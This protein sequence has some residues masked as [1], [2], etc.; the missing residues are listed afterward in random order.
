V[1]TF[2]KHKDTKTPRKG[3]LHFK[4]VFTFP[5]AFVDAVLVSDTMQ[6]RFLLKLPTFTG[7]ETVLE[8]CLQ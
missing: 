7:A 3:L 6:S 5:E 4:C 2:P 8:N 1:I